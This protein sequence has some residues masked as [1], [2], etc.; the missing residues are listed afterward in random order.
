V[1]LTSTVIWVSS[2]SPASL[3]ETVSVEPLRLDLLVGHVLNG[4]N[5]N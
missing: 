4:V 3:P 1:A 2:P 5:G